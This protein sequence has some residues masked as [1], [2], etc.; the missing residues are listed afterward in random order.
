[1]LPPHDLLDR[2][3]AEGRV[4][5][6]VAAAV[7]AERRSAALGAIDALL[8][9]RSDARRRALCDALQLRARVEA[10]RRQRRRAGAPDAVQLL[11]VH[12]AKGLEARA[13]FVMDAD[14]E[15][16]NAESATLADR[17]AGRRRCSR[18]CCAF[19]Y[20]ELYCPPSLEPLRDRELVARRREELNGLYV[21]MTRA[22]SD[23]SSVRPNRSDRRLPSWWSRV[24]P[25]GA[26]AGGRASD[27][28]RP[29]ARCRSACARCRAE[30]CRRGGGD[31]PARACRR[32]ARPTMR[33]DSVRRAPG[34]R[35][36]SGRPGCSLT[37]ADLR[38]PRRASSMRR[39]SRYAAGRA[40]LDQPVVR[41]LLRGTCLAL[42]RQRGAG[43]RGR[44]G[45]AA[46]TG[47]WRWRTA[48]LGLVG[49][50]LQAAACARGARGLS[51]AAA[52][53][54]RA[55]QALQAGCRGARAFITGAGVRDRGPARSMGHAAG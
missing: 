8:G 28:R 19:V 10:P 20:S 2:I 17:L 40:H 42:G 26:Q 39:R 27:P 23:W 16:L 36:G 9:C 30:R 18:R 7:P 29:A 25:C 46:S 21:A 31:R 50:R 53:Y 5:E 37:S 51:R 44:R 55:V 32:P 38:T 43:C 35:M 14:P 22:A 6:R 47:W 4:R 1:M 41:A 12:G 54:A 49:A 52:R 48:M 13:V 3:V 24:E 15:P 45:P 11:T 34:A 33:A